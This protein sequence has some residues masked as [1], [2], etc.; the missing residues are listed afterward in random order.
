MKN[1]II[2]VV[3]II[4][5][6]GGIWAW[7]NFGQPEDALTPKEEEKLPEEKQK[8]ELQ[9]TEISFY[10]DVL[11]GICGSQVISEEMREE[12]CQLLE[13]YDPLAQEIE[14]M[15]TWLIE[16]QGNS[17]ESVKIM[18]ELPDWL[19]YEDGLFPSGSKFNFNNEDRAV[20]LEIGEIPANFP[21][22]SFAFKTSLKLKDQPI[23]GDILFNSVLTGKDTVTGEEIKLEAPAVPTTRVQ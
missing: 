2:V 15:I 13:P 10:Q 21:P 11:Y 12:I 17:V 1:I 5:V 22:T 8:Q 20:I 23:I 6:G 7:Q 9:E 4:L 14:L 3:V 16:N 19:Q 18:T